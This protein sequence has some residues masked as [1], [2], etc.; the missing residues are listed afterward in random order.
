MTLDVLYLP[1]LVIA[2]MFYRLQ[3]SIRVMLRLFKDNDFTM[4]QNASVFKG[5]V[6]IVV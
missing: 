6:T 1:S 4:A 3:I 2:R 5:T